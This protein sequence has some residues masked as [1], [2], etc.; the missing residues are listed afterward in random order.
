M[1][2]GGNHEYSGERYGLTVYSQ[3]GVG[4]RVNVRL[5]R[6]RSKEEWEGKTI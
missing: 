2:H 5:P 6:I 4:T 1:K 3:L